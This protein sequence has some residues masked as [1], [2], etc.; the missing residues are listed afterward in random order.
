MS[1]LATRLQVRALIFGTQFPGTSIKQERIIL[2]ARRLSRA[3]PW[4]FLVRVHATRGNNIYYK[5][6]LISLQAPSSVNLSKM[7]QSAASGHETLTSCHYFLP[8][9]L[10]IP[11]PLIFFTNMS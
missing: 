1:L 6:L 9:V 10:C 11:Q 4:S 8:H 5:Q 7:F 3:S 2:L